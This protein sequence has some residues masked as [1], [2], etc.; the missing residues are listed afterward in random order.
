MSCPQ[1]WNI[2]KETDRE[3]EKVG[4]RSGKL[5]EK[6]SDREPKQEIKTKESNFVERTTW[7]FCSGCGK[8]RNERAEATKVKMS[9]SGKKVN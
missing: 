6:T 3:K 9:G 5:N 8:M 1:I 4:Y 7:K 2:E